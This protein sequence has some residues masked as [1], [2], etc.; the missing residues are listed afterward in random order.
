MD[1]YFHAVKPP[2]KETRKGRSMGALLA[3]Y[4]VNLL[5]DLEAEEVEDHLILCDGCK[6]R[7]LTVRELRGLALIARTGGMAKAAWL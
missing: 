5:E 7:Y 1:T 3:D 2:C 4:I 6:E